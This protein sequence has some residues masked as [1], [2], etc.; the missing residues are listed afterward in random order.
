[1]VTGEAPAIYQFTTSW[2]KLADLEEDDRV[3]FFEDGADETETGFEATLK[4]YTW[5]LGEL[6]EYP[7]ATNDIF[8][9]DRDN[10]QFRF[11]GTTCVSYPTPATNLLS[12]VQKGAIDAADFQEGDVVAKTSDLGSI[13]VQNK[14][15]FKESI[16]V[17]AGLVSL[18][19]PGSGNTWK[20]K[21]L[22]IVSTVAS[23]DT[24]FNLKITDGSTAKYLCYL[25][26]IQ[27]GD[28][29]GL[30]NFISLP[31]GW[32]LQIQCTQGSLDVIG[33]GQDG[34]TDTV[35]A[36]GSKAVEDYVAISAP[37]S[38]KRW[39][40]KLCTCPTGAGNSVV[41]GKNNGGS[42]TVQ[43]LNSCALK[44]GETLLFEDCVLENPET[45][46][47]KAVGYGFDYV[48]F[49]VEGDI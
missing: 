47:L 36:M 3:V 1:M 28:T 46:D 16:T 27:L 48:L 19:N 34:A 23:G 38:G 14:R 32:F 20:I 35:L 31:T 33:V 8:Y 37:A 24:I 9:S 21:S 29:I 39:S 41:S 30:D 43:L 22:K 25:S 6:N 13:E 2:A 17:G 5:E 49:G 10:E 11:N 18:P 40:Y 4:I 15:L 45:L 26:T 44:V 42:Y 7:L 12:N